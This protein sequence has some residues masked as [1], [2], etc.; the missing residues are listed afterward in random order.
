MVQISNLTP[1]K[2]SKIL[3]RYGELDGI[4]KAKVQRFFG[5]FKDKRY[6]ILIFL[7]NA[8][9]IK[10]FEIDKTGF[11]AMSAWISVSDVNSI[12]KD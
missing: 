1:A 12:K 9:K 6:C 3:S 5:I 7:K 8:R 11:G 4:E 10:P 2:V